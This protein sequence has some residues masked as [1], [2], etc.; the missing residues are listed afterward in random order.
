M[1][2]WKKARKKPVEI[3][4]REPKSQKFD[5]SQGEGNGHWVEEI[6]TLENKRNESLY[7]VVGQ[8]FVIRGVKGELYPIK[9]EI[10]YQTYDIV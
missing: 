6:T 3:E 7:A 1:N 9:K 2:E 4:F 10:F 5:T 8:D